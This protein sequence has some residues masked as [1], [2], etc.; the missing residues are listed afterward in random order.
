MSE[1][2]WMGRAECLGVIDEMWDESTPSPDALRFCFRCPVRTECLD[3]GLRRPYASDAGVLG[4]VGVYDRQRVREGKTTVEKAT[5]LRLND[6]IVA[7][8]DAA[9]AEDFQRTMPQ[10][11]LA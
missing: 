7:D 10:L 2:E 4:G 1:L 5:R 11:A 9:L 3:Y 6:L 8:W